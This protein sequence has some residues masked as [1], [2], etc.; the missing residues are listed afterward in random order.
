MSATKNNQPPSVMRVTKSL[1]V[2]EVAIADLM[3]TW[4]TKKI[5]VIL[6]SATKNDHPPSVMHVTKSL[7]VY[8]VATANFM[9]SG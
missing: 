5:P 8:G 3:L 1:P 4:V 2:Y 6:M 7:P 9:W